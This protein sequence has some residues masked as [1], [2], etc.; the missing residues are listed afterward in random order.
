MASLIDSMAQR[1]LHVR[2]DV[3]LF[4]AVLP[5]R[6]IGH[7]IERMGA[8]IRKARALRGRMIEAKR[9]HNTLAPVHAPSLPLHQTIAR[10]KAAAASLRPRL[11]RP[12]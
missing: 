6:D 8:H 11:S 10:A 1:A 12:L 3:K 5:P 9:L 7:Q 4:F 2:M